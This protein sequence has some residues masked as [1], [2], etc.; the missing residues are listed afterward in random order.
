MDLRGALASFPRVDLSALRRGAPVT[1]ATRVAI[2][3][4]CIDLRVALRRMFPALRYTLTEVC[5]V[6]LIE[7]AIEKRACDVVIVDIERQDEWAEAVFARFDQAAAHF[8]VIILCKKR[9]EIL[10]YFWKAQ[11][12]TDIVSYEAINDPRF[13]CLIEAA[14][15]RAELTTDISIEDRGDS[16]APS[17][18]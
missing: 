17:A 11:H 5:S 9:Q 2:L 15:F 13:V 10:T 1:S 16:A 12:A 4:E 7:Q 3:S 8:P 18:A 6:G 14:V